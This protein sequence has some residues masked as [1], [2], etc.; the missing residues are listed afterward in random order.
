MNSAERHGALTVGTVAPIVLVTE[1]DTGVVERG[2]PAVR[3]GDAVSVSRQIG[4]HRLRPGQGRLA[5]HHPPLLTERQQVTEKARRSLKA[6]V[7][8]EELEPT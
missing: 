6:D 1:G 2:Q 4:E 5:V 7:V 3:D 8:T